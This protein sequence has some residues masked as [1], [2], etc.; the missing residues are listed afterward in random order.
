MVVRRIADKNMNELSPD[1]LAKMKR[2]A[3]H[4]Q[5]TIGDVY[6]HYYDI[7]QKHPEYSEQGALTFAY[8]HCKNDI[9]ELSSPVT[10]CSA[11]TIVRHRKENCNAFTAIL[12]DDLL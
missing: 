3:A 8:K 7:K 10:A 9:I 4:L 11:R 2:Y 5:C 12:I 1:L 6:L